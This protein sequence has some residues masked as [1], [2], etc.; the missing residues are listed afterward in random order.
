[1]DKKPIQP[2][3]IVIREFR[4]IKGQIDSPFEFRI[5]NIES[6]GFK[7]DFNAGLNLDE[8]LIKADF[9][10]NFS[11]ISKE[12]S[13]EA[14]GMYHFVFI[15]FLDNLSDH[16]AL[17]EDGDVDWN[18][19]LANAIASITYSTSRGI[20]LSRFQ[21]TVMKDF[22]LP[23]VDPNSLLENNQSEQKSAPK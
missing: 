14:T 18:P 17:K 8:Y 2:E 23:V 13:I 10:I 22:I 11:T 16:A 4:L 21:G 20:L 6:Y 19:Y 15:F 7:V 12:K 1:M 3:R 9:I 5:S